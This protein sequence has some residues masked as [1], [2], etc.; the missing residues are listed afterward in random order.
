[1]AR[2]WFGTDG[3]RGVANERLSPELALR[4]GRA[5]ALRL[6][7]SHP[8]PVILIGRDTRR[9]G[10][11]LE[12]ALAAG[13]AS[14]GGHAV[15]LGVVP[16]PA[17]A[18]GVVQR[19]AAAGIV[20][21]ASHNPY[22]DNGIKLFGA[23]GYKLLDAEEEAIEALLETDVDLPTGGD[24]GTTS[25]AMGAA[26][27]YAEWVAEV[28]GVPLTGMRIV[29]DCAHGAAATVAPRL[30]ELLGA[31]VVL[32]A[33]EPDGCNIN[34]ECGSTHLGHVAAAVVAEGATLG[35]AF[36]GDADRV[37][38][39]DADGN[40]VDGDH[41]L[42]LLAADAIARD[43]LPG[44]RVVVTSMANLGAHHA[45]RALGCTL[46]ITDVGDRYVLEAMRRDGSVLGGEQ[47]G[48]VIA[49]D[50]QTT[51]DGPLTATLV[52]AAL[53]RSGQTLAEAAS[54]VEKFPQNLISVRA[55][56]EGLGECAPL[57]DAIAAAEVQLGDNGRIVVRASGTEPLV[58]VMVEARDGAEC[59]AIAE[60]LVAIVERELPVPH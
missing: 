34:V 23:D 41:I 51:G 18:W 13:I 36:D 47:S 33:C 25:T 44:N 37:L 49:L 54:A 26:E 22:P 15:R 43:A 35:V 17:V 59:R 27:A 46:E 38:F 4:V 39:V 2:A 60:E 52:L 28:A 31:D 55:R 16:T 11:M 8:A 29:V 10:T 19:G 42:T 21:S 45:L 6:R 50:H 3:I 5:A 7:D 9:S 30:F 20:I 53:A 12:D 24:V 32:I 14:A 57:W 48:H 1:M 40:P 58:R 56:R